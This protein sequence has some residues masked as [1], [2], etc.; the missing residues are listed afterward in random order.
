M[1]LILSS[2]MVNASIVRKVTTLPH[3]IC[4]NGPR[5]AQNGINGLACSVYFEKK[6]MACNRT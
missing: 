5:D 2:F 6:E 1:N 4:S 3:F